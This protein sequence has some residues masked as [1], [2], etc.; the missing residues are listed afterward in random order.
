[1]KLKFEYSEEEK[2]A[3]LEQHNLF[4][5][6]LQ[7]KVKR[8][9]INEQVVGG[10]VPKKSG[11]DLLTAAIRAC[12]IARGGKLRSENGDP[13]NPTV[14]YKVADYDSE[15]ANS[16]KIGDELFIKDNFTL[17][18]V[19]TDA[20]GNKTLF[21]TGRTWECPELDAEAEAEAAKSA[22]EIAAK[23]KQTANDALANT[24][25]S[26]TKSEGDWKERKDITDTDDNVENPQMYEKKV[27]N[28]ITLYRSKASSAI[29]SGLTK[30]QKSIID[31]WSSKGYKLRKDLT[32]EQAETFVSK[33]VWPA[34]KGIFSQDLIMYYDPTTYNTGVKTGKKIKNRKGVETD[35]MDSI[36]NIINRAVESRIPKS[37]DDCKSTIEAYFIS[38]KKKRPLLPNEFESLKTKTQACKN[39]YY[40][41]WGALLSGGKKVDEL[42]DIMSG[43]QS[44]GPSSYGEDSKW[45]IQ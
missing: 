9:M 22:A 6:T 2:K 36:T 5:K 13:K 21:A 34:S 44:G 31:D 42:L 16:F 25:I 11:K 33:V 3:I 24:N 38:F 26:R 41:D 7:S 39:E 29:A 12:K 8:L 27:V 19:K 23:E 40:G 14:I 32:P 30:D 1:M 28:G 20:S 10:A 35:E 45:R 18:I 43:K 37:K 4:K 15:N 17:D